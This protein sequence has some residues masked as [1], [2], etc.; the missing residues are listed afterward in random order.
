MD[1]RNDPPTHH[2]FVH[3]SSSATLN[4]DTDCIAQDVEKST[5]APKDQPPG[6]PEGPTKEFILLPIP[7]YLRHIPG[8]S[9]EFHLPRIFLLSISTIFRK[10]LSPELMSHFC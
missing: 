5:I 3:M 6:A 10:V 8:D 4:D 1:I 9:I 7:R 2:N